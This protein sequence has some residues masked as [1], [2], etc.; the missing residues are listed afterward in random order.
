MIVL[1]LCCVGFLFS[2]KPSE[3]YLT[4]YLIEVI[5]LSSTEVDEDVYPLWTYAS[6]AFFPLVSLLLHFFD[7]RVIVGVGLI[8]RLVTR[9]L[10]LFGRARDL[11]AIQLTQWTFGLATSCEPA[12]FAMIYSKLSRHDYATY[13][14]LSRSSVLSG[15]LLAG[16]LGQALV[17]SGHD[18]EYRVLF[19]ISAVSVTSACI[20]F[21]ATMA[22]MKT[23]ESR[24]GT[25]EERSLVAPPQPESSSRLQDG[26]EECALVEMRET[27]STVTALDI[28]TPSASFDGSP[29]TAGPTQSSSTPAPTPHSDT[30]SWIGIWRHRGLK[31]LVRDLS[32]EYRS[33]GVLYWSLWWWCGYG[34]LELV[35]NYNTSLFYERDPEMDYDGAVVSIGR[36]VAAVTSIIPAW[37]GIPQKKATMFIILIVG[38]GIGAVLLFLSAVLPS[39]YVAYTLFILFYGVM[40]LL[41]TLAASSI[42]TCVT[43]P[44]RAPLIFSVN[45]FI[46]FAMQSVTQTVIGHEV[47]HMKGH[48]KFMVFAVQLTILA[49]I[50][51]IWAVIHGVH[52]HARSRRSHRNSVMDDAV[53]GNS[54]LHYTRMTETDIETSKVESDGSINKIKNMNDH[55]RMDGHGAMEGSI[56]SQLVPIA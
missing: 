29:S 17:S 2:F 54:I 31:A 26:D 45:A 20:M 19:W 33:P 9:G 7:A 37:S 8:G 3:P 41:C 40:Q 18:H 6:V 10:L 14:G 56:P 23:Q 46:S 43:R 5:G 38:N 35:L 12:F 21:G 25:K 28:L 51:L 36:G 32:N 11:T 30:E 52:H 42:A 34:V 22:M 4:K 47:L 50:F 49:G 53:D 13:T 24:N 55:V 48:Q 39:I 27:D 44:E 15:H 1:L 16:V